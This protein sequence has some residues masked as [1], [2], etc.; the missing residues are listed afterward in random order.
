MQFYGY[1][2]GP[3]ICRATGACR[4]V[5]C[6]CLLF[7]IC[8]NRVDSLRAE[9]SAEFKN[10]SQLQELAQES[11]Q[12][13]GRLQA[14]V[15][16]EHSGV[17]STSALARELS[18][19][20]QLELTT[21]RRL[22]LREQRS[23]S[24]SGDGQ[25]AAQAELKIPSSFLEVDELRETLETKQRQLA[26]LDLELEASQAVALNTRRRL[27]EID[28]QVRKMLSQFKHSNLPPK[29]SQR[30]E[31]DLLALER[32]VL[33]SQLD[34]EHE[35]I[36][37][38]TEDKERALRNA[39]ELEHLVTAYD[40]RYRLTQEELDRRLK[41]VEQT[42]A[43]ISDQLDGANAGLAA[44]L[45]QKISSSPLETSAAHEES[46]LLQQLLAEIAQIEECWR[47]RF[48]LSNSSPAA[49]EV[50]RWLE[51]SQ[52]AQ[53]QLTRIAE[54]ANAKL[55]ASTATCSHLSPATLK[56][57]RQN[58][59]TS[60]QRGFIAQQ[61]S[62]LGAECRTP[63]VD[64]R[65]RSPVSEIYRRFKSTTITFFYGRL[66]QFDQNLCNRSVGIRTRSD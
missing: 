49:A 20:E 27:E 11:Q 55:A 6:C 65:R 32:R 36:Q 66:A 30:Q 15:A 21:A 56:C 43:N 51:E 41:L 37:L 54:T 18:F 4:P 64:R 47:R 61:Q 1:D 10:L 40:H 24:P 38:L 3:L 39:S 45:H 19:W 59:I 23:L 46:Q 17:S 5:L 52:M 31:Q 26:S 48:S 35:Q 29:P 34:F 50:N 14:A 28:R 57:S 16:A 9:H 13:I 8:A 25:A 53:Q 7:A 60:Q 58:G 2:F 44:I 63:N 12:N 33:A 62:L 22:A 42:A